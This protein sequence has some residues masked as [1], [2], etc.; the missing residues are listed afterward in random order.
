[1]GMRTGLRGGFGFLTAI[2]CLC[3]AAAAP[4]EASSDSAPGGS[5]DKLENVTVTAKKLEEEL[6]QI[7]ESQGIHVD[8]ITAAQ[9][10][11]GGYV[12]VAT[13]LQYLAPGLFI[14]PKNGPFDY[15]K[16]SLQGS[17]TEDVLWLVDGV[18]MNNRLYGGTTPLDTLPASIVDRIEILQGGQAL[19]YGTE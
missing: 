5:D 4:A 11:H 2:V 17:R 16:V 12:D 19:Y 6:P 13:A 15:V 14:S 7:L 8:T 3:G 18:R 1:M 9:I 10:A